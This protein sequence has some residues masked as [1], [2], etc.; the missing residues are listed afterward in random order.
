MLRLDAADEHADAAVRTLREL[1]ARW[2]LASALG[3]RGAIHRLAGRLED[4]ERDL[5][6]AFVLCRDLKERALVGWTA[7][8]LARTLT[9][10]GDTGGAEELL[11]DQAVRSVDG[12]A[13]L[14]SA[15]LEAEAAAAL[16]QGDRD[17]ALA[18]SVEALE[19]ERAVGLPNP[20]AA[21]VWWVGSLFG[22]DR[23]RGEG[24]RTRGA[25]AIGAQRMAPG[26][27]RAEA[28]RALAL[29][30]IGWLQRPSG[31]GRLCGPSGRRST[32]GPVR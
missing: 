19:A 27:R 25:R 6:E 15:L 30:P 13:G 18:R 17:V 21:H 7:A 24:R 31:P 5:R 3:E 12:E 16:A 29:S 8:E 2:E 20:I 14:A 23:C 22:P 32:P 26:P 4:A 1:G 28:R 10:R 9:A 11:A